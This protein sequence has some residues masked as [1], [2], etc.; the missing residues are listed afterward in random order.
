MLPSTQSFPSDIKSTLDMCLYLWRINRIYGAVYNRV[1]SYFIT[2]LEFDDKSDKRERDSLRDVLVN[3]LGLFS[4][5][6]QGG[7]ELAIYGNGFARCVEPFDRWLIDDRDGRYQAIALSAYP[8]DQVTYNWSD[9]TYTVPDLHAAKG[10]TRKRRREGNIPKVTLKFRDKPAAAPER[11]S[12]IFLDPRYVA[13]DK[14]HHSDSIQ[15]VYTIPPDMES[16]IKSGVLHEINNTPRGLLE[17]VAKNK[18]FRFR[19]NEVFHFRAPTPTGVSDSGW[20][21]PEILLHYDAIYQLQVY[22]KADFAIAQDFL[23]PLRVFSPN[24]GDKVGDSTMTLL[25]SRW[26]QEMARMIAA[27]RADPTAIHALP[28]GV[29]YDQ[30]SGDGKRMVMHEVVTAYTDALFDGMG[31][32]RELFRGSMTNEQLPNAIRMFERHYEWLFQI[33]NGFLQFVAKTVQRALDTDELKV[34]L[35]R[36]VM[37]YT[38]EWMQLKMQLAANREIPR[39]DVYPDIGVKDPEAAAMRAI[40]E[41]QNI[42]RES[43]EA[44][45][46]FEKERTQGSMADVAIMAAEQGAAPAQGGGEPA[47]APAGAPA[48]AGGGQP[49]DYAVDPG[50]DPLQITQRAQEIATE[51][52]RMHTAQPNSHK[53][54]MQQCE[55]TNPTLYASAK[56]EMEKMRSQAGSQGRA[57]VG[58]MLG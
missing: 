22:R 27:H 24:F 16:R 1:V 58:Q 3:M 12:V 26:R 37:A 5:M 49:L 52:L 11:F 2:D 50:A 56:Q 14:A 41:D 20:A 29:K 4:K 44:S 9:L 55:A 36:P 53:K 28:F 25:M 33:L 13:L 15:Y 39:A 8:E 21:C 54:G 48:A 6:Q 32:P 40:M 18:D 35:K 51:W 19:S 23:T 46:K 7:Q 30:F 57:Q 38:A 31:F 45:A 47:G 43:A 34:S 42:Q 17:A 10:M